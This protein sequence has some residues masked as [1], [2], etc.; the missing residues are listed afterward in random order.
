ME[1]SNFT[2]FSATLVFCFNS[3]HPNGCEVV[4]SD[5]LDDLMILM[6]S[7]L[8]WLVT[9]SIFSNACWPFVYHLWEMSMQILCSFLSRIYLIFLLLLSCRG[10]IC[11]LDVNLSSDIWFANIFSSVACLF[12]QLCLLMHKSFWVWDKSHL[13]LF[14][15]VVC[16]FCVISKKS[17]PSS[18]SWSIP[19]IF[20]SRN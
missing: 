10:L 4:S 19:S 1:V 17:W 14:I 18:M 2:A 7:F 15:F 5:D 20:S 13:S 12:T 11:I 8:R 6:I 16:S 3:R 9:Q